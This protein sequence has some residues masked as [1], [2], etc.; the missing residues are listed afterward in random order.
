MTHSRL[1]HLRAALSYA[2][3]GALAGLL[4]AAVALGMAQLVA[5][6]G[7]P[8]GEPVIAVGSAAI[9]L[10][11]VPVKDFAIQHFGSHDKTVL[12]GGILAVLAMLAMASGIAA[13]R[14]RGYG[15]GRAGRAGSAGGGRGADP[16]D[17]RPGRCHPRRRRRARGRTGP[18]PAGPRRG[19]RSSIRRR[20]L[21]RNE[22]LRGTACPRPRACRGAPSGGPGR[23]RGE[24]R[25]A[26]PP[27]VPAHRRR[28]HRGRRRRGSQRPGAAAPVQRGGVPGQDR[29]PGGQDHRPGRA[30]RRAAGRPRHHPVQHHGR[31][32]LPGRHGPD[33]AAGPAGAMAAAGAWPG[34]TGTGHH[35]R[36]AA[37]AAAHRGGHHPGLRV[38]PGRRPLRG[39]RPVA[40]GQP[41]RAAARG[42]GA[43]RRRPD[44]EHVL[45]R[46]DLRHPHRDRDGRPERADRGGHERAAAAG[47]PWLPG[48]DDGARPVRLRVGHQVGGGPGDHHVLRAARLLGAARLLRPGPD[49]D[50]ITDRR[51]QAA[52]PG[53]GGP[54]HRGRG[55]L[56]AAP[57]HR[58]RAG[59]GRERPVAPGPPG[60]RPRHRHLAPVGLVLGRHPG[61][62]QL[63]VRAVD[64]TGAVQ[65][66]RRVPIVP[67]GAT[68]WDTTT[69]TV[70]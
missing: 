30:A 8:S 12:I 1:R 41:G 60:R 16:A 61:L 67:N 50:R 5:A 63:Q 14:R 31:Q 57:R 45:R 62:H 4:A 69:V 17:R 49:Q 53:Q 21:P 65:P 43:P 10:T 39:Q 28:G 54:G 36:R 37:Q 11:P 20:P 13:R 40:G 66:S 46:L 24:P 42:T 9:D 55:G 29:A 2:A 27:P 23:R 47:G 68:G 64:G 48:P 58:R 44:P 22:K 56:G 35:L 32:F 15:T 59:P 51:A 33:P 18:A 3:T 70:T 19:T 52:G 26:E 25:G 6:A 34:R 7:G 38:Q